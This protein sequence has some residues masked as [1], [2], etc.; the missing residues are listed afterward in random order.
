MLLDKN[1][2]LSSN[3]FIVRF[4]CVIIGLDYAFYSW[5]AL[6]SNS[7]QPLTCDVRAVVP[8]AGVDHDG[9]KS[10]SFLFTPLR[11][12]TSALWLK[13]VVNFFL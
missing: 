3:L 2:R 5:L 6:I 13:N 11:H 10:R 7:V 4:F 8:T 12:N 1:Q 9:L